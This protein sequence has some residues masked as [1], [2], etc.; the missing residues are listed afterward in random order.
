MPTGSEKGR[1]CGLGEREAGDDGE[2]IGGGEY[3]SR[4]ASGRNALGEGGYESYAW[5]TGWKVGAL[6]ELAWRANCLAYSARSRASTETSEDS[7]RS[8]NPCEVYLAAGSPPSMLCRG[9]GSKGSGDQGRRKREAGGGV[10]RRFGADILVVKV[11]K[12]RQ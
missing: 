9:L 4:L 10:S 1:W 12:G 5:K 6:R 7:L 8:M 2:R 3:E 11:V